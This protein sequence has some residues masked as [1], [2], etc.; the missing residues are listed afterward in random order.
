MTKKLSSLIGMPY[1]DF[2]TIVGAK[3]N[4]DITLRHARLIPPY[5]LGDESALT[6]IFLSSLRLIN[7]FR[8]AISSAVGLS[9]SGTIHVFTELCFGKFLDKRV[10]GLILVVRAGKIKDAALLELKNKDNELNPLQIQNYVDIAKFYG[11]P[12]LIT[13]S[14]QFVSVPTQSPVTV[15]LP[16]DVFLY[17]LS[18]SYILTIAQLLLFD[19]DMNIND[20][21]QVEI[22]KEIMQYL[23]NPQAGVRGFTCMKPGWKEVVHKTNTGTHLKLDD[24]D[25]DE[26]VC[27]WLQ[28]EKD[29][30]MILSRK[31]GQLVRSGEK[32]HRANLQGRIDDAKNSL[33]KDKHVSATLIVEGTAS[34]IHIRANLDRRNIVMSMTLPPPMDRK[35]KAQINWMLNQMRRCQTKNP[36]LFSMLASEIRVDIGIKYQ[37]HRERLTLEKLESAWELLK[38]REIKEFTVLQVKDLGRKFESRTGFISTIEQMLL[39]YYQ[40]IVQHLKRWEKPAPK[41]HV[42]KAEDTVVSSEE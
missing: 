39:D 24:P 26:A 9:T 23:E 34:N 13:I 6:S 30:A 4:K 11:I 1:N 21:D 14:N 41:M 29:M 31:L 38:D 3:D 19:N 40:G 18:W 28:E 36:N 2:E 7:E 12:R 17:H 33:I 22:M 35:T 8:G 27:S 20:P 16:K 10:D 37:S 42:Q 25:I 5:K 15:K 32:K